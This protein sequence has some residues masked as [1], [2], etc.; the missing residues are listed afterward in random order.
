MSGVI[1]CKP[2]K[3]LSYMNTTAIIIKL[4]PIKYLNLFCTLFVALVNYNKHIR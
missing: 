2:G 4:V 1:L 3:S